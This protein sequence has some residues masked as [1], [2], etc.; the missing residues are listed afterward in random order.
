MAPARPPV[1]GRSPER[2]L[3]PADRKRSGSPLALALAAFASPSGRAR[4]VA[5]RAFG[6]G[7]VLFSGSLYALALGAPH[8]IGAITPLGGVAFIAG[9]VALG[10]ALRSRA[11]S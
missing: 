6:L 5:R 3:P 1:A 2:D 4:D 8:W 9:W 10:L 11:T 7:I